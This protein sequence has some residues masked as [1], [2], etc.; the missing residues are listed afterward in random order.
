MDWWTFLKLVAFV[1]SLFGRYTSHS[2]ARSIGTRDGSATDAS[3]GRMRNEFAKNLC[4]ID[5]GKRVVGHVNCADDSAIVAVSCSLNSS[6]F[7]PCTCTCN[8]P[9]LIRSHCG[10]PLDQ[11]MKYFGCKFTDLFGMRKTVSRFPLPSF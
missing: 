5:T 7:Y 10:R 6:L 3:N 9:G 11:M 8:L 1:G 4:S 2:M